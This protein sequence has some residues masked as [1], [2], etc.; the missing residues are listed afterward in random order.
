MIRPGDFRPSSRSG[1]EWLDLTEGIHT[2]GHA[3][4]S[5]HFDNEKPAHRALVGPVRLA[6]NLVT[7][8]EWLAFMAGRRL[9]HA[10]AVADGRLCRRQQR[11]MAG[12]RPLAQDRRPM[13][14]HDAGGSAADRSGRAGLSCQLL[15]GRCVRALERQA[16]A[17]RDGMGGR[18]ARR[19]AQRRLR[20]RL[21]MDPQRLCALPRLPRHR[22][23]ARRIQRQVHGQPAGAARLVA[24]N[25]GRTQP[26]HLSQLLLSAPPLAI[27]GTAARRLRQPDLLCDSYQPRRDAR[28]GEYHECACCRFGQ[29][30][31]RSTSRRRPSRTT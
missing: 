8:G 14:D 15:R 18:R 28:S 5:F 31:P 30:A 23:R 24:C 27:H 7:N 13:A 20:H 16:S 12:A 17:D 19:P 21:A 22:R 1:D 10:D 29:S 11:G 6:R 26:Y 3:G 2:I 25:A 4:D 9:P